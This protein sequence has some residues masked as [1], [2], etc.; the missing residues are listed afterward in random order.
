MFY[1]IHLFILL[2]L[3][4]FLLLFFFPI[5]FFPILFSLYFLYFFFLFYFVSIKAGF[6][7]CWGNCSFPIT[8]SYNSL[9]PSLRR[10]RQLGFG[11]LDAGSERGMRHIPWDC[12]VPKKPWG[13]GKSKRFNFQV[14]PNEHIFSSSVFSFSFSC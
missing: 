7:I 3:S 5:F 2:F 10:L 12:S 1:F 8:L 14:F 9:F 11:L 4:F 6:F 13:K